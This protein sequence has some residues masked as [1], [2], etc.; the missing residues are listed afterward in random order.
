MRSPISGQKNHFEA[1]ALKFTTRRTCVCHFLCPAEDLSSA[2]LNSPAEASLPQN[3]TPSSPCASSLRPPAHLFHFLCP[4]PHC[5]ACSLAVLPE[6]WGFMTSGSSG[7]V[8]KDSILSCSNVSSD[9]VTG[10]R[11]RQQ[12]ERVERG[13]VSQSKSSHQRGKS[14]L[15][16]I[17]ITGNRWIK[18]VVL[19]TQTES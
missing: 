6:S 7:G 4:L 13:H 18:G 19:T 9:R 16:N 10:D 17:K 5:T 14:E 11:E 3:S 1:P 2:R 12:W 8:E 15:L